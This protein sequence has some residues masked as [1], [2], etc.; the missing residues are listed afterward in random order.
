MIPERLRESLQK[1]GKAP[2]SIESPEYPLDSLEKKGEFLTLEELNAVNE[3]LL[4]LDG[5]RG[6]D[7]VDS[8]IIKSLNSVIIRRS[9]DIKWT[10]EACSECMAELRTKSEKDKKSFFN[11]KIIV[12]QIA[13]SAPI[14]DMDGGDGAFQDIA[15]EDDGGVLGSS[16]RRSSRNS[17]P[18]GRKEVFVSSNDMLG[19]LRLNLNQEHGFSPVGQHLFFKNAELG[20]DDNQKT[21]ESFGITAGCTV[22]L[23]IDKLGKSKA[24]KEK[25]QNDEDILLSQLFSYVESADADR[26]EA[27]SGSGSARAVERGFENSWLTSN[28]NGASREQEIVVVVDSD[29]EKEEII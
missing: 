17:A 5:I 25:H 4:Q 14:P 7:S 6:I 1:G 23:Q 22:Y 24:E 29:E 20:F 10:N 13:S 3:S 21:L 18:R 15:D 19:K 8:S 9:N 28:G 12:V 26:T 16:G 2:K 11:K 27:G